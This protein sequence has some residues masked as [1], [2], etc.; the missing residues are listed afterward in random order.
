MN[1]HLSTWDAVD[2]RSDVADG[3]PSPQATQQD[4]RIALFRHRQ[5]FRSDP[6]AYLTPAEADALVRSSNARRVLHSRAVQLL[7]PLLYSRQGESA[8]MGPRVTE[9]A[10]QDIPRYIE[11]VAAWSPTQKEHKHGQQIDGSSGRAA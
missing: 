4:K 5:S 7:E 6:W 11:L 9:L 8:R 10:A 2:A 1:L 3:E